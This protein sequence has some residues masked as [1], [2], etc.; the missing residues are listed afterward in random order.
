M[1][2]MIPP[3]VHPGSTSRGEVEVFRRLRDDPLTANWTVLHSLDIAT[4][5]RKI[6]G[7]ADFVILVP[8]K[9]V[10]CIEVK[11]TSHIRRHDGLWFYGHD[12]IPDARGPFKQAA[13]A[14]HSLR[15]KCIEQRP[16]LSH[17]LFWSAVIF[18]YVEFN[19]TSDEWH[20]WQVISSP[21]FHRES[22]S[23]L[24]LEVLEI[25]RN[26]VA[27]R[28]S[29]TWF[30]EKAA[31]PYQEQCQI[32]TDI[33]R[34][35]FEIFESA[36]LRKSSLQQELKQYTTEQLEAL[37]TMEENKRVTFIG[38]AGTGKTLLAVEAARRGYTNNKSLL[39]VCF[40]RHLGRWLEEVSSQWQ[41]NVVTGTLHRLMMNVAN[42]ESIPPD[43]DRDFW[44]K[45]LPRLALQHIAEKDLATEEFDELIVDEAQDI[46]S[47]PY[48]D[49]L[50]SMLKG[51]LSAGK[52][53][54]FGDFEKQAIYGID[55]DSPEVVLK[56]RCSNA[57][58][59]SLRT[60]CRNTPRVAEWAHIL[61]NLNPPY[62]KILRPDDG[63]NPE[64]IFYSD[65][66]QA[67]EILQQTL[68][69]L[70]TTGFSEED[71]VILSLKNDEICLATSLSTELWKNKMKPF[72]RPGS[73][74][75]AFT[76][77]HA[78]K[79]LEAPCIVLTDVDTISSP[80]A[81]SLFYVAVTRTL[82]RLIILASESVKGQLNDV[83]LGRQNTNSNGG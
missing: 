23:S 15:K 46:L 22:I 50:D 38:P 24:I 59:Y 57:P 71:I 2:R 4:H 52:W 13:Q 6:A 11:G 53:R 26:F 16:D 33:L 9:G 61:G 58:I 77:V 81:I 12:V 19:I 21:S 39:F 67:K 31:E 25:A 83:L 42:I 62:R 63:I 37:D 51:G 45:Q 80:Y 28:P 17:I 72:S 20:S 60:N 34:P 14:M 68:K 64:I 3:V 48:L 7:E 55:G 54:L 43:S 49:F 73:G 27:N 56:Q 1:A 35:D 18:P 10:L 30:H 41:P 75:I 5:T 79:G 70:T 36:V 44:S 65:I 40:N 74:K 29:T 82:Q 8:S 76:S 66:S 32:I 78:F 47:N 69:K